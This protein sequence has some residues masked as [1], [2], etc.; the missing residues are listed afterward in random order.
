VVECRPCGDERACS[1]SISG[2]QVCRDSFLK[3]KIGS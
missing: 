3:L 1:K 2:T